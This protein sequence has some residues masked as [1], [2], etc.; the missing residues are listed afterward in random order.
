MPISMYLKQ[1]ALEAAEKAV[2]ENLDEVE[3]D[4]L[5]GLF[6]IKKDKL[7]NGCIPLGAIELQNEIFLIHKKPPSTRR[8]PK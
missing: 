6:V 8:T 5:K 1:K 3:V 7:P 2:S 4:F